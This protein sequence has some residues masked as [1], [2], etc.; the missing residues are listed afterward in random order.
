MNMLSP[1]ALSYLFPGKLSYEV[2][3][4]GYADVVPPEPSFFDWEAREESFPHL[5]M[6]QRS[7]RVAAEPASSRATPDPD[8]LDPRTEAILRE[9]ER[10]QETYGVSLEDLEIIM[11]Y[12]VTLSSLFITRDRRI[13]LRDFNNLEVRMDHISKALYFLYLRHPEGIR[14]KDAAALVQDDYVVD[15]HDCSV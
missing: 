10:I 3:F 8:A 5:S 12:S 1:Q 2:A 7:R 6:I 9:L 11:G 15:V 4:S 14:V 13:Y